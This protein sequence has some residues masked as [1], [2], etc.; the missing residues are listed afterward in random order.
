[1]EKNSKQITG[2]IIISVALLLLIGS[3][4]GLFLAKNKPNK[5]SSIQ[6]FTDCE[7]AGYPIMESYPRQCRTSDGKSFTEEITSESKLTE[8]T[9]LKGEIVKLKTPFA[10]SQV[11]NPLEITGEIKGTW[12]FEG[13][14]PVVLTDWDGKIIAEGQAK[15]EKDWMTT[16]YVPFKAILNYEK[17]QVS[18][19]GALILKKDNP[20]GLPANDDSIEIT[21]FLK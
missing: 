1:M 7:K 16:E 13:T 5:I 4:V 2:I 10:N 17:P 9:S 8:Y 15:L 19:R 20:S 6:N 3:T 18:N 12:S 21:V 14:F 11:E